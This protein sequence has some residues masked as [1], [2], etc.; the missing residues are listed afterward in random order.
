M[1]HSRKIIF[2]LL[3]L[4]FPIHFC[5]FSTLL[6]H[7]VCVVFHS[8][9]FPFPWILNFAMFKS[10]PQCAVSS[11]PWTIRPQNMQG[12][13]PHVAIKEHFLYWGQWG[14]NISVTNFQPFLSLK[15]CPALK[16]SIHDYIWLHHSKHKAHV[17]VE[18]FDCCMLCLKKKWGDKEQISETTT[19]T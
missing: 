11:G 4:S 15:L 1:I 18:W 19:F 9:Q 12:F 5:I 14:T 8:S 2:L 7:L 3:S 17:G 6:C 16:G 13:R 10:R